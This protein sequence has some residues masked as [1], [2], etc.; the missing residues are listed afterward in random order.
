MTDEPSTQDVDQILSSLESLLDRIEDEAPG[1]RGGST[2]LPAS[3]KRFMGRADTASLARS[4]NNS[5]D[6]LRKILDI[7]EDHSTD[8]DARLSDS[9]RLAAG[10][11]EDILRDLADELE[12]VSAPEEVVDAVDKHRKA[13]EALLDA[14]E[15]ATP[16]K[17][18]T[19]RAMEEMQSSIAAD[20][21]L[22][23]T[24][25]TD[26][27]TEHDGGTD[28]EQELDMIK[29]ELDLDDQSE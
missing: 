3:V 10:E 12:D 27:T 24:E 11:L 21:D 26:Q 29:D 19:T 7:D 8:E 6:D 13:L 18:P 5:V 16:D 4:A 25:A 23:T 22:T 28:V 17:D 15:D 20:D 9:A 1:G 14:T 2:L